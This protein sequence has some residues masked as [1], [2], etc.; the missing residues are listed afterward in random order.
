MS[1]PRRAIAGPAP[2]G[3]GELEP[4][5]ARAA[6][7]R[8]VVRARAVPDV[9][10]D[11]LDRQLHLA[12]RG[13]PVEHGVER[14]LLGDAAV[15]RLLAAEPGGE[16][17]RLAAVVAERGERAHQEVAVG[18]RVADVERRVPGGEHRDI[19]LVQLGDRQDVVGLQLVLGNLIDPGTDRLAQELAARLAADRVGD[20]PDRVGGIDEAEGHRARR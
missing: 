15:D 12:N 9:K 2:A 3:V 20:G 18:H 4:H 8:L 7:A 1:V 16:L 5:S 17:E 11:R 10:L 19:V 13:E 6:L 14:D